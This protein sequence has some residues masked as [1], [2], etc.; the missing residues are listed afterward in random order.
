MKLEDAN[1]QD[2]LHQLALTDPFT[3]LVFQEQFKHSVVAQSE[4]TSTL[5]P[6]PLPQRDDSH[7]D[8]ALAHQRHAPELS[9]LLHSKCW[10]P[11]RVSHALL[12]LN[13]RTRMETDLRVYGEMHCTNM[14]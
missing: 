8:I 9:G 14:R 5:R 7:I 10:L 4:V 2:N 6:S 13:K 3:R 12:L 1:T 11:T